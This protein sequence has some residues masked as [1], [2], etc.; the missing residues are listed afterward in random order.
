[1]EPNESQTNGATAN[2]TLPPPPP[3]TRPATRVGL[4][5]RIS[6][7]ALQA[8]VF[9]NETPIQP[10]AA[11]APT[12]PPATEVPKPEDS[13]IPEEIRK[14]PKASDNFKKLR[15]ERDE[16]RKKWETTDAELKKRASVQLP[17]WDEIP[18]VKAILQERD[19]YSEKLK[20]LD[21]ERHDGFKR[22]F[23]TPIEAEMKRS[24]QLSGASKTKF[25]AVLNMPEG[26]DK[27][28]ALN[29]LYENMSVRERTIAASIEGNV[30]QLR[31]RKAAELARYK[32]L[33][34]KMLQIEKEKME[35]ENKRRTQAAE[36]AFRS[37]LS[38]AQDPENGLHLF[39][40]RDGDEA[41]N[42]QIDEAVAQ[43]QAIY[44]GSM[45]LPELGKAALWASAAPLLLKDSLAKAKQIETLSKELAD[46]KA[47]SPSPNPNP[48][49]ITNPNGKPESISERITRLAVDGGAVRRA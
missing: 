12:N 11:V 49:P 8:G 7:Q 22:E 17:K 42:K 6:Q 26:E 18:E 16:F 39:Q 32:E 33:H 9:P 46:L 31:E 5:D 41:W 13:E 28:A 47:A 14:S 24:N 37:A 3:T 27:I 29:D 15:N 30:G 43:A 44:T 38:S 19:D 40:K 20:I 45:E 10:P 2:A 35:S 1:M 36:E 25:L 23:D 48:I 21:I 34:P 4:A